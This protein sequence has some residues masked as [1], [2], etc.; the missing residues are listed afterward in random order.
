M[1]S[2]SEAYANLL[3]ELEN[4][5][6]KQRKIDKA[7]EVHTFFASRKQDLENGTLI[8]LKVENIEYDYADM[9]CQPRSENINEARVNEYYYQAINGYQGFY[10]LRSALKVAPNPTPGK[11]RFKGICGHHRFKVAE[12]AGYEYVVCEVVDGFFELPEEDQTDLM[13]CDNSHGNNGMRSDRKSLLSSLARVLGSK[14]YMADE[15]SAVKMIQE[16]LD[17]YSSSNEEEKKVLKRFQKEQEEK[18]KADMRSKINKWTANG[19][20]SSNVSTIATKAYKNWSSV[21][22]TKIYVPDKD[23]ADNM[24][25]SHALTSF[26]KDDLY[27]RF[28]QTISN[29]RVDDRQIF[30][31]IGKMIKKYKDENQKYPQK[32]NLAVHLAGAPTIKDLLEQR[33]KFAKQV[34]D[35]VDFISPSTKMSV[36]FYGQIKVEQFYEDNTRFYSVKDSETKLKNISNMS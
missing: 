24:L 3:A 8:V 28:G 30:G 17:D 7:C 2:K 15:R 32:F 10:G 26:G 4:K 34:E 19:L 31:E 1:N 11:K 27:K 5:E 21:D 29:K 22:I 33:L 23:E 35:W 14:T 36:S 18:I 20:S 9:S 16:K 13:M 12:K 25:A 6:E